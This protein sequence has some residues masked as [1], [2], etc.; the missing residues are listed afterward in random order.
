MAFLSTGLVTAA[1]SI[2]YST[3]THTA[4]DPPGVVGLAVMPGAVAKRAMMA[5]SSMATKTRTAGRNAL[6]ISTVHNP[7]HYDRA[8]VEELDIDGDGST[9]ET[10]L[11][12]DDEGRVLYAFSPG[13]F[14]CQRNGTAVADL[15]VAALGTDNPGNRPVGSGFWIANLEKG[16][17]GSESEML[18][19]CRFDATGEA[20][21]CGP[22]TI[23]AKHDDL[24]LTATR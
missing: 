4:D 23:D 24:I 6:L 20:T 13:T 10:S 17:C 5:P 1:G 22:A 2:F 21:E 18:W 19:G 8:W 16:A 11:V 3:T 12:W 9:E 14:T 7:N 15:L